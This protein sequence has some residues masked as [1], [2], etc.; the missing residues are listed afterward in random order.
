MIGALRVNMI[1]PSKQEGHEGHGL[2]IS[3]LIQD[4]MLKP[5]GH[6]A[7]GPRRKKTCLP[8]VRQSVFQTSLL[9]YRD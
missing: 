1:G 3:V 5:S 8:G 7:Y 6:D 2:L 4:G 9:S